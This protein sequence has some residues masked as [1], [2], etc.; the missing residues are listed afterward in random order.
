MMFL[1]MEKNF[2]PVIVDL[3]PIRVSSGGLSSILGSGSCLSVVELTCYFND[4]SLA[5]VI[6]FCSAGKTTLDL[7][8]I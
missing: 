3:L 7:A 4:G 6:C 8:K 5:R 2:V 1:M